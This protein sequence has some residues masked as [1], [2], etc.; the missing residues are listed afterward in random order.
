[1]SQSKKNIICLSSWFP[2]D[3]QPFL[4]NFI[5]RQLELLGTNYSIQ[6]IQTVAVKHQKTIEVVQL[7]K[8]NFIE[9]KATYPIVKSKLLK[10][11]YQTK[12]L[13]KA[14]LQV[15]NPQLL[16]SFTFFPKI[17]Q[18]LLVKKRLN[19]PWIHIEHG[20]YFRKEIQSNWTFLQRFWIKKAYQQ[21]DKI[22][23]VSAFLAK[24]MQTVDSVKQIKIIKNHI[25][26]HLFSWKEKENKSGIHFLHI[27]TLDEKTKNPKGIFDAFKIL[28]NTTPDFLLT[29][30][31]DE[32]TEKWESYVK[33]LEI[34]D[35]VCFVPPQNWENLPAFYHEADAFV[36][37]ST[38]ETFSIVLAEAW[39]TGTPTISTPVGIAYNAPSYL[40]L[41]VEP[42]NTRSLAAALIEFTTTKNQ[43]N[44]SKINSYAQQFDSKIVLAELTAEIDQLLS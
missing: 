24:D 26:T 17:W 23:S 25:D 35:K 28:S 42:N 33:Q 6:F 19:I 30:V 38:Y 14:L 32:P 4:G 2:S 11:Y 15:D 20:S 5:Q 13:K 10:K 9:I 34:S 43:F 21:T 16:L 12:A 29:I 22:L 40:G 39:A 44:A 1:M 3:D 18:F 37:N 7:Q 36:L 8:N 31:S 27:S 41:N